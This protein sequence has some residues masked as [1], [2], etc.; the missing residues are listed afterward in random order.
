MPRSAS[1]TIQTSLPTPDVSGLIGEVRGTP[2][3]SWSPSGDQTGQGGGSPSPTSMVR[4]SETVPSSL[5]SAT[6]RAAFRYVPVAPSS[7]LIVRAP[8]PFRRRGF[9]HPARR[10]D[11]ADRRRPCRVPM[12][13]RGSWSSAANQMSRSS[14]TAAGSLR[15]GERDPAVGDRCGSLCPA[16]RPAG[17]LRRRRR[18]ARQRPGPAAATGGGAVQLCHASRRRRFGPRRIRAQLAIER[19]AESVSQLAFKSSVCHAQR[20]V[21]AAAPGSG[22][23]TTLSRSRARESI[24]PTFVEVVLRIRAI[25][26]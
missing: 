16:L 2:N 25:V 22:S 23:R 13:R 12:T 4:R 1:V 11:T 21:V 3:A 18:S 17:P 20:P 26:A 8:P 7:R 9:G 15:N 5:T 6:T 19:L 14:S 10:P 24:A